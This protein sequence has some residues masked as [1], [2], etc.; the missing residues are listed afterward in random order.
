MPVVTQRHVP[1]VQTAQETEEASQAQF[2][3]PVVDVPVVVQRQ[4]PVPQTTA[5]IMKTT[6]SMLQERIPERIVEETDID[7]SRMTEEILNVAKHGPQERFSNADTC[8][9]EVDVIMTLVCGNSSS[10][11]GNASTRTRPQQSCAG[12]Q[13]QGG[14]L[15]CSKGCPAWAGVS[16]LAIKGKMTL[17]EENLRKLSGPPGVLTD[18]KTEIERITVDLKAAAEALKMQSCTTEQTVAVPIPRV[19]GGNSRS[20]HS[21]GTC[22]ES[23]QLNNSLTCQT[24]R[25]RSRLCSRTRPCT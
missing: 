14:K 10:V 5:E 9:T 11:G 4:V 24:H 23:Q 18:L 2:L 22:A 3:D 8:S 12:D 20:C 1:T 21:T 13:V 19:M 25:F 17:A 16:P 15:W 7:V 6:Q